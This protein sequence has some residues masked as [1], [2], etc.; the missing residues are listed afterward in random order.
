[1]VDDISLGPR[2]EYTFA[3]LSGDHAIAAIF[4]PAFEIIS[5]AFDKSQYG[6]DEVANIIVTLQ[7]H[8]YEGNVDVA[9]TISPR[10]GQPIGQSTGSTTLSSGG[11]A[12]VPF[13]WDI[14]DV[15]GQT[16]IDVAV[17]ATGGGCPAQLSLSGAAVVNELTA[18]EIQLAQQQLQNCGTTT[19]QTCQDSPESIVMSAAPMLGTAHGLFG[20]IYD[21]CLAVEYWHAGRR[22][23]SAVMWLV[24]AVDVLGNAVSF[25]GD[26]GCVTTGI[27][28]GP[29]W[30]GDLVPGAVSGAITCLTSLFDPI[31]VQGTMATRIRRPSADDQ[32]MQW[33]PDSLQQ[34]FADGGHSLANLAVWSGPTDIKV[35]ADSSFTTADSIGHHG[36]VVLRLAT[37]PIAFAA[38]EQGAARPYR[39]NGN[40]T[41]AA[42]IQQVATAPGTCQL[43]LYHRSANGETARLMYAPAIL[44][45]GGTAILTTSRDSTAFELK[46]D[47]DGDGVVDWLHYP[48]GAVVSVPTVGPAPASTRPTQVVRVVPNPT[49]AQANIYLR[50][51]MTSVPTR[52]LVHD[53]AGRKVLDRDLGPLQPGEQIIP[54]DGRDRFGHQM[55]PGLYFVQVASR[56]GVSRPVRLVQLH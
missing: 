35:E 43:A 44:D 37:H 8:G 25:W 48:G 21:A 52:L 49:S 42:V 55:S 38:V 36:V 6:R 46:V 19:T 7:S 12:S 39:A 54:W 15:Q 4:L 27:G 5:A 23:Q 9:L 50:V 41:D 13:A 56:N 11:T 2:T 22:T 14:P 20:T 17:T 45:S 1:V 3:N 31:P 16:I 24:T 10:F 28:C 51:S 30:V 32:L 47:E 26:V 53:V 29:R 34:A 40:P 18:A 33:L